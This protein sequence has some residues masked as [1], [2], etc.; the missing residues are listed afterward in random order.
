MKK[1]RI[2]LIEDN[3]I[4]LDGLSKLVD[5]QHDMMLAG[6][7]R[8][9]DDVL[10]KVRKAR[11][12]IA[13]VGTV[14][15]DESGA[16]IARSL[17]SEMPDLKIIGMGLSASRSD[18][19]DFVRGGATGFILKDAGPA[20]VLETIRWVARESKVILPFI[21]D[22]LFLHKTKQPSEAALDDQN[23]LGAPL[24]KREREIVQLIA[25]SSTN[26]EIARTLNIAT[27]TVKSHVHNILVR[28]GLHS[29]LQIAKYAF[30][31]QPLAGNTYIHPIEEYRSAAR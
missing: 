24:T 4:L 11:P 8:G 13:L 16:L 29:R 17:K 12:H 5:G 2:F 31:S 6:T 18:I 19:A 3:R 22:T 21:P 7:A 14:V 9:G 15:L 25:D 27:F 26:K 1:T 30:V 23:N 10:Q 28:L 20:D